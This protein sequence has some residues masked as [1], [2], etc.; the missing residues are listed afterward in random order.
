M[1]VGLDG[2]HNKKCRHGVHEGVD[3]KVDCPRRISV[4][5]ALAARF[6]A[7]VE[8]LVRAAEAGAPK[9]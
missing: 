2:V 5:G 1:E 7:A 3:E 9:I 4:A 6:R 8:C